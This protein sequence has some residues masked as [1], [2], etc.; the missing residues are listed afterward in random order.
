LQPLVGGS[1]TAGGGSTTVN[2]ITFQGVNA[3]SV[4]APTLQTP[5][6]G[7]GV[8]IP[9]NYFYVLGNSPPGT[10]TAGTTTPYENG[11]LQPGTNIP[12][13]TYPPGVPTHRFPPAPPPSGAPVP[14]VIQSLNLGTGFDPLNGTAPTNLKLYPGVLPGIA[15]ASTSTT[16]PPVTN[17]LW[18]IPYP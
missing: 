6:A 1:G 17:Y 14:A 5:V 13:G 15:A 9:T 2:G 8:A 18:K 12:R 10:T 4:P 11:P 16:T 3:S 7:A